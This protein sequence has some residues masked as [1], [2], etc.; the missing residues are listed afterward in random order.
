MPKKIS[1][2]FQ[3]A[4]IIS[5]YSGISTASRSRDIPPENFEELHLLRMTLRAFFLQECYHKVNNPFIRNYLICI[6]VNLSLHEVPHVY[7]CTELAEDSF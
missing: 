3:N 7:S 4:N 2:S 6:F 5:Y 1:N